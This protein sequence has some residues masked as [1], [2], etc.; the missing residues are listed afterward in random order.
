MLGRRQKRR[1]KRIVRGARGGG[2]GVHLTTR[3]HRWRRSHRWRFSRA[4]EKERGTKR[5]SAKKRE[6]K[7][8]GEEGQEEGGKKGQRTELAD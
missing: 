1:T 2:K 8:D 7:K 3:T 6:I 4:T 5:W